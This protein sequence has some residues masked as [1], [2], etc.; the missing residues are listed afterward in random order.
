MLKKQFPI[1]RQLDKMDCALACL[2]MVAKYY[3]SYN[4]F[5]TENYQYYTSKDGIS[6][7][8]VI[9][10]A[11]IINFNV[12][13]GKI[14]I[15]QLIEEALL[16]CILFWNKGHYV[17][18]YK[19][20]ENKDPKKTKFYIADPSD[21]KVCYSYNDILKYWICTE[22]EQN[23]ES[24]HGIVL[25]LE[26]NE[27]TIT[28]KSGKNKNI[29]Q[30]NYSIASFILKY[31]K[32]FLFLSST[33]LLGGV[34]ELF[35]P[36][37]TQFIVDRGIKNRDLNFIFYILLGQF[38]LLISTMV[39]DFFRRWFVLHLGSRFSIQLL[40]D[41]MRKMMKL[42]VR[43]FDSKHIGD[44]L[45]RLQDHEKIE[46]FITTH[47]VNFL[48]S[49]ITLIVFSIV[50][51]IYN[52]KIFIIYVLGSTVY[53]VWISLFLNKRKQI[54]YQIFSIKSQSQS[55]YHEI[56]KGINEIKLQN[57]NEKK[58]QEIE[59]IQNE[60]YQTNIR[61]LKLDQYLESGNVFFNETK[62][63]LITFLSAY[64][65]INGE[66]TLGI[67]LSVQ[68]IIGQLN[69]PINQSITFLY[70]FQDARLSMNRINDVFIK[71]EE[72][73]AGLCNNNISS[74]SI[75]ISNLYF[76]YT[77]SESNNILEN[78]NI[79]IP[80]NKITA[81]VGT[82]GSG[83]TT[84]LKLLLKFYPLNSG[85][86]KIGDTNLSDLDTYMWREKCGVVLQ[87]GYI[88]SDS[89]KNNISL[90]RG[91]DTE[92]LIYATQIA[93]IY[94]FITELPF[95][96]DTQIGDNGI[97]LSQGQKQRLLIA[98]AIYKNPEYIFFDEATNAL[99][100][101]NEK[102]ITDNL[103]KFLQGKTSII[104]AHR[105][106]SVKNADLILVMNEGKIVEQGTHDELITLGN[107]YYQ[108]IKNQLELGS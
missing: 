53:I 105:L 88:F 12:V 19:I 91:I 3:N 69:V 94:D 38:C 108:L 56:I 102:V 31:R 61:G 52:T 62:N 2:K 68:Y 18:L 43:F 32:S 9:E 64:F 21:G 99:D 97:N 42:P 71:K 5:D 74:K 95:K 11:K 29:N 72:Q 60:L 54:N 70:A 10:I 107:H 44:I 80:Q 51:A 49:L 33:I 46:R 30:N 63:I 36:F 83:K 77:L 7:S 79:T 92:K 85:S 6:I 76:N 48:F 1:I 96:F 55:K 100:A 50:L 4:E 86:I 41:L 35:F 93:N 40:S 57:F 89:I 28:N 101:K 25:L 67:M 87:D 65:V 104:I 84:L 45:Q 24:H 22:N 78:I 75:T 8:S 103:Y 39:N 106:S 16:P 26:P 23:K 17:V 14:T 73:T 15:D 98:R 66:L 58:N 81:I 90:S 20:K 59:K 34:L 37:L 27:H 47:T 82:S 13:C